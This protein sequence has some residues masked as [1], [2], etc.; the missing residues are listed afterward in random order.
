MHEK[1][2]GQWQA[3]KG[4]RLFSALANDIGHMLP[5]QTGFVHAALVQILDDEPEAVPMPLAKTLTDPSCNQATQG[6]YL[7]AWPSTAFGQA[8]NSLL[9]TK[10]R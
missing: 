3:T 1:W 6:D 5:V 7:V 8:G 9:C 4:N 10:T 2:C